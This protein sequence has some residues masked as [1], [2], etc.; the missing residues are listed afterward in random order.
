MAIVQ[1]LHNT[2]DQDPY[3]ETLGVITL[4]DVIEEILQSEIV[5]ETD[6]K[7]EYPCI[8]VSY[9]GAC[10]WGC[11]GSI[12]PRVTCFFFIWGGQHS[13]PF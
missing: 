13:S 8:V 2:D 7:S 11:V 3:F 5:D 6:L 4:E 10:Q 1:K 12:P 9:T